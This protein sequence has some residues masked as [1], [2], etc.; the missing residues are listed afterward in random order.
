VFRPTKLDS[1]SGKDF[2]ALIYVRRSLY[3]AAT[4]KHNACGIAARCSV[5]EARDPLRI[6]ALRLGLVEEM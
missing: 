3:E 4:A 2:R 5:R 1:R 6:H